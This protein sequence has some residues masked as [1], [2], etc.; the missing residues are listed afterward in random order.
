MRAT[1]LLSHILLKMLILHQ[2]NRTDLHVLQMTDATLRGPISRAH[3]QLHVRFARFSI[4]ESS[5]GNET[6]PTFAQSM[7]IATLPTQP[8]KRPAQAH[9]L[10]PL[11]L[12]QL[13]T[14]PCR[15]LPTISSG[16]MFRSMV[17]TFALS[18]ILVHQSQRCLAAQPLAWAFDGTHNARFFSDTLTVPLTLYGLIQADVTLDGHQFQIPI[19]VLERLGPDMLIGIDLA[20]TADLNVHFTRNRFALTVFTTSAPTSSFI[21]V[22]SLSA[23]GH[24][25]LQT[26]GDL[27]NKFSLVFAQDDSDFGRIHG[28]QHEIRLQPDAKPWNKQPFRLSAPKE[29]IMKQ[30][31]QKMLDAGI[32]RASRAPNACPAFLVS[33]AR[34][35][36]RPVV[37]FRP[38]NKVT[39]PERNPLPIIRD[40]IDKLSGSAFFTTLDVA[41]GYWHVPLHP[42]SIE[43]TSFVT[44]FGQFEFH[45][46]PMGLRNAT[47]VFQR[48]MRHLLRDFLGKGVEQFLD[49]IIIHTQTE[50]EHVALIERVLQCLTEHRI[51]LRKEKCLFMQ[52][53]VEFLGHHV[54]AGQVRPSSKKIKAIIEF[55][56]PTSVR[57]IREFIGMANFYRPFVPNFSAIAKPLTDLLKSESQFEWPSDGPEEHAFQE[58]KRI[59][60]SAPILHIFDP[61]LPC[62]LWTDSSEVGLGAVLQQKTPDNQTRTIAF[63]SSKL[64]DAEQ[65]YAATERECLAVV[66][67]IEHFQVYLD[68]THFTVV[69]DCQALSW[70]FSLK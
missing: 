25:S 7:P 3:Q 9:L 59:L 61:S 54:S 42:N 40:L 41:W 21:E 65:R 14:C 29:A 55:P 69:S 2:L 43:K 23:L 20:R 31:I 26:I 5:T 67:A 11:P 13:T 16:L 18:W 56:R 70:V 15:C 64:N 36:W 4:A 44:T 32:I 35:E 52:R 51:K 24:Q 33:K 45:F 48:V 46:L 17:C 53:Q 37:D 22:V 58:L 62:V 66:R 49:D 57:S 10:M 27:L 38:V 6:V 8:T 47:S 1:S 39:I 50:E 12:L 68:G 34:G 60:S 19:H 28:F 63:W 30:L